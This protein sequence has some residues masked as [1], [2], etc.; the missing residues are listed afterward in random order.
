MI[1]GHR[2]VVT[3]LGVVTPVGVGISET[4]NNLVSGVSGVSRITSFD[5]SPYPCKVAGE[6]K[7]FD[8]SQFFDSKVA[9]RNDLNTLYA[10]AGTKLAVA[11][12]EIHLDAED[13]SR[14]GVIIGSGVGGIAAI[15]NQTK[16]FHDKGPRYVS[17]FMIPNLISN[18]ASGVVAIELGLCGPNFSTVSA[19]ATGAHSIGEAF[20]MLKLGKADA[21]FTGGTEA[22]VTPLSFAGFCTMH[23]MSTSYNDV[24][25]TAS[26][27]F[28]AT[29]DGFVMGDGSGVLL[30]ETLEHALSRGAKIYCE[31]V[32][33]AATCDAYHITAP[34]PTGKGLLN[35][36][37]SLMEESGLHASD[38]KYINAHGTSTQ[39]NDKMET[40]AIKQFFGEHAKKLLISSTKG[41][42]GHLLGATGAVEAAVCAKVIETGVVPP[43]INYVNPDPECDLNYV[44]NKSVSSDI[45]CA[46]SENMGFGG[47][48]AALMFKKFNG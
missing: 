40:F 12:S 43:T 25:E 29:R 6:I 38:V 24:P 45:D 11:D 9:R 22:G 18:M 35:C 30:L 46:I 27:P 28:D 21:I 19:C 16:I 14:I 13:R 31:V 3:G 20:N 42:T 34:D 2:V 23:T 7:K 37:K 36:Y 41:A 44:P 33:Y 39:L 1:A 15:C 8:G 32:G 47:Q 4:W 26:R 10:I 17:P 5:T 48:N